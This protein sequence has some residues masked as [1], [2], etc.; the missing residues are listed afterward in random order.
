[1][2]EV[3]HVR[4]SSSRRRHT[5]EYRLDRDLFDGLMKAKGKGGLT[6]SAV[7]R[8]LQVPK[9]TWIR[10]Y[11]GRCEP[12]LRVSMRVAEYAGTTVHKLFDLQPVGDR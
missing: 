6:A 2:N 11:H 8:E 3:S 7:S 9:S 10:V 4:H 12:T 1:M 5:T